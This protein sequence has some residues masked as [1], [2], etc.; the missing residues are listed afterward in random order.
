[1]LTLGRKSSGWLVASLVLLPGP[2]WATGLVS[3]AEAHWAASVDRAS[4]NFLSPLRQANARHPLYLWTRLTGNAAAIEVLRSE[5][6]LPIRH[7]WTS[8]V[9]GLRLPQ[10]LEDTP[11]EAI[12]L[13]IDEHDSA[14]VKGLQ[15][16]VDARGFFDWRTWSEKQNIYAGLWIVS[17]QYADGTAVMCGGVPCRYTIA[18]K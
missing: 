13:D 5:R 4:G 17:V 9:A 15:R 3:V 2:V 14:I 7:C 12:K 18:V 16:E 11:L 10:P 8:S 6:K 1:M